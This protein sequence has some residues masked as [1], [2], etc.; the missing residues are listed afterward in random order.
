MNLILKRVLSGAHLTV[1]LLALLALVVC[2]AG[3]AQRLFALQSPPEVDEPLEP[4][5]W[6]QQP[7]P[8]AG[9]GEMANASRPWTEQPAYLQA[10]LAL[11]GSNGPLRSGAVLPPCNVSITSAG[12]HPVPVCS[13]TGF[14]NPELGRR[15][16]LLG[17]KPSGTS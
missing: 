17:H 3:A 10:T 15:L 6:L 1:V 2:E 14:I 12:N 7:D 4:A 9:T 5:M 16:T 11:P 13:H 8:E